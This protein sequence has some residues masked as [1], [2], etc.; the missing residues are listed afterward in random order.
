MTGTNEKTV[1]LVGI[2]AMDDLI[3]LFG[4]FDENLRVIEEETGTRITVAEEGIRIE[5]GEEMTAL[6][7]TVLDEE[8]I[9]TDISDSITFKVSPVYPFKNGERTL[10]AHWVQP[11]SFIAPEDGDYTLWTESDEWIEVQIIDLDVVFCNINA[12]TTRSL[13]MYSKNST[14]S[15]RICTIPADTKLSVTAYDRT[16]A[17]VKYGGKRGFVQHKYLRK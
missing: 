2:E 13:A 17:Y 14:S 5:G 8:G 6:T 11:Y 16:W 9:P 1:Q 4:V 3:G 12:S 10:R 7:A 15:K